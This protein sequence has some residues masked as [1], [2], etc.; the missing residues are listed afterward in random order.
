MLGGV[1]GPSERTAG[2]A[3]S[4]PALVSIVIPAYNAAKYLREAID[5]VLGQRYR[6]I[7]TILVDDGSTDGTAAIAEGY[8]ADIR[9][10]RQANAG[11]SA[12]L[13]R[14]WEF[15][16]GDLLGYLSADDRLHADA[17]ASL[18]EALGQNPTAVLAYP[19]FALIDEAARQIREVQT[20]AYDQELLIA[21]GIC[22]AGPGALFRR[23]AFAAAGGWDTGLSQI[24]DYEFLL[25]L[26]LLGPF[27]RLPRVV[28]D[29]R[30]H[31]ESATYRASSID[32]ADEPVRVMRSF[33][34]RADLPATVARWRRTA[35]ANA[36]TLS[37][38]RHARSG[39]FGRGGQLLIQA[40]L[41]NPFVAWSRRTASLVLQML[42]EG[43]R[44]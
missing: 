44:R 22:L 16:R 6:P 10:L 33:Y 26:S 31:E 9:L 40:L 4:E 34:A 35:M 2:E 5:S 27:V 7:E 1:T 13:N 21:G 39:Q 28:A 37:A 14:G 18:V 41:W 17:V 19:D 43:N 23:S 38:Y 20:Q 11:Q 8:G 36:C 32:R 25:R 24:P 42:H 12:A 29:F 15:A 30:I 3:G